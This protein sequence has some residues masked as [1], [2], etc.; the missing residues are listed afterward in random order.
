MS[1]PDDKSVVWISVPLSE[2]TA[3]RL[4]NLSD[5]CRAD[6]VG[7]AASLLHDILKD[8]EETHYL[9]DGKPPAGTLFN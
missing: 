1:D 8:D 2:E 5:Q 3:T 9:T 4:Q 7:V 6:P